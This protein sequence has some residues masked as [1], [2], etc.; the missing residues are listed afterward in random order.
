MTAASLL[1]RRARLLCVHAL[2]EEWPSLEEAFGRAGF[3]ARL[4][5]DASSALGF[6]E[7]A[8]FDLVL[9]QA[10]ASR[11]TSGAWLVGE[12]AS[13]GLLGDAEACIFAT[14]PDRDLEIL[15]ALRVLEPPRGSSSLAGEVAVLLRQELSDR[16]S[17]FRVRLPNLAGA[18]GIEQVRWAPA[19][20]RD[21]RALGPAIPRGA[22]ESWPGDL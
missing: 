4:T 19:L 10:V 1:G 2:G 9:V 13:R 20:P 5:S 11:E 16:V 22:R 8:S 15:H 3:S 18:D 7:D 6:L 17:V 14:A 21:R 12:A